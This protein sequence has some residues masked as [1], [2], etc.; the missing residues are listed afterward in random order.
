MSLKLSD[1]K[2][3]ICKLA[4]IKEIPFSAIE[5][6]EPYKDYHSDI[7]LMGNGGFL[8]YTGLFRNKELGKY[9]ASS[10]I[11]AKPFISVRKAERFTSPAANSGKK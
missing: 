11:T 9:T 4:G 6:I 5:K 1:D 7:R 8:G 10:E 3:T 2:R